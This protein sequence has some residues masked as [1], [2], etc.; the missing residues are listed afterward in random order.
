MSL[1]VTNVLN[2]KW[3]MWHF[4][5]GQGLWLTG[6]YKSYIEKIKFIV[7][8]NSAGQ[9]KYVQWLTDPQATAFSSITLLQPLYFIYELC[10]FLGRWVINPRSHNRLLAHMTIVLILMILLSYW[11][12]LVQ[13]VINYCFARSHQEVESTWKLLSFIYIETLML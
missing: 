1:G 6:E 4:K 2:I 8:H 10:R 9:I 11:T 3:P 5:K 7:L 13:H 12:S